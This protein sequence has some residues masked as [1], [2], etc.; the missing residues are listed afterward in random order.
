M[1]FMKRFVHRVRWFWS[2]GRYE[3]FIPESFLACLFSMSAI[4]IIYLVN[5]FFLGDFLPYSYPFGWGVVY[6]SF[7]FAFFISP[8]KYTFPL[9]LCILLFDFLYF[10]FYLSCFY[11]SVL[12]WGFR[13][14]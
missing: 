10:S 8:F 13:F 5:G 11:F 12:F 9:V 4:G 1:K 6:C 2:G 14:V 7:A 3:K